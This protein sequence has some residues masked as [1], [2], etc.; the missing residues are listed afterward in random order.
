MSLSGKNIIILLLQWLFVSLFIYM[1]THS[2]DSIHLDAFRG[3][4]L[5]MQ[6]LNTYF[7]FFIA[8]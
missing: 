3:I 1:S 5:D 2:K 8:C 6:K 7:S 4:H